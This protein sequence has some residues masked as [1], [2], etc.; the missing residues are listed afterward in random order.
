VLQTTARERGFL[1]LVRL[2]LIQSLKAARAA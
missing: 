2:P 1:A